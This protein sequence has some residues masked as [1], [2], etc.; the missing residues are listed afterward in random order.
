MDGASRFVYSREAQRSGKVVHL[1]SGI[2]TK[3]TLLALLSRELS[4]PGY[5]G[6]NWDALVDCL[7]D[8]S[9]LGVDSVSL[10]H[11]SLPA[12]PTEELKTYLECLQDV[13]SRRGPGDVPSLHLVFNERDFE[14]IQELLGR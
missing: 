6:A 5:F 10:V 4:F 2:L 7:S 1:G 9:W 8:L 12:L 13:L 14:R 11:D 3:G